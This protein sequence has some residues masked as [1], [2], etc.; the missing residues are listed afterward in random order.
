MAAISAADINAG[1][2]L[3]S[4]PSTTCL[5]KRTR[6]RVAYGALP[7]VGAVAGVR[8]FEGAGKQQPRLVSASVSTP[9]NYTF[10]FG[11][12][13]QRP[14]L[15]LPGVSR[16]QQAAY[17]P[18][19]IHVTDVNTTHFTIGNQFT[20][21]L[22]LD[23]VLLDGLTDDMTY[24]QPAPSCNSNGACNT[25]G[26]RVLS[27]PFVFPWP[28]PS[29]HVP[30]AFIVVPEVVAGG[31]YAPS[32]SGST[33]ALSGSP[34][35]SISMKL[36]PTSG[37]AGNITAFTAGFLLT[38]H[39]ATRA[40][41]YRYEC[42][43][44]SRTSNTACPLAYNGPTGANCTDREMDIYIA[45][46]R[47]MT[48][49]PDIALS[50]IAA[51]GNPAFNV[52]FE[53]YVYGASI[54]GFTLLITA[55]CTTRLWA[56]EVSWLAVSVT[57]APTPFQ[58]VGRSRYGYYYR[59]C[60]N[61]DNA[62]VL[63]YTMS[64]NDAG[65]TIERCAALTRASNLTFFGIRNGLD[66][67]AGNEG[68]W[69]LRSYDT[70]AACAVPC[71]GSASMGCGDAT[72]MSVYQLA[73][74][75]FTLS[76]QTDLSGAE[77][78]CRAS[79]GV[80]AMPLSGEESAA[81]A[82]AAAG[83]LNETIGAP[84]VQLYLRLGMWRN[85][86]TPSTDRETGW[87]VA[88][89]RP[90][91][92]NYLNWRNP[93]IGPYPAQPNGNAGDLCAIGFSS[94]VL[95]EDN[96]C[97]Y[98][99]TPVFAL[100]EQVTW[101]GCYADSS[102]TPFLPNYLGWVGGIEVCA[103][104]ARLEGYSLFA[105]RA[106]TNCYG[107]NDSSI[108]TGATRGT[109][110]VD[111]S[112]Y[113]PTQPRN[114]QLLK[115]GGSSASA[116]FTAGN[117]FCRGPLAN[118]GNM[119]ANNVPSS[120]T[121]L[122]TFFDRNFRAAPV[123]LYALH[124][125][126][127]PSQTLSVSLNLND[128]TWDRLTF[129][130]DV[131]NMTYGGN[132]G[133]LEYMEANWLALDGLPHG[134]KVTRGI[135]CSGG[136]C[137]GASSC[138]SYSYPPLA[139]GAPLPF[140]AVWAT[141]DGGSTASLSGNTL[142]ICPVS[143]SS[144]NTFRADLVLVD[145]AVVQTGWVKWACPAGQENNSTACP[146]SAVSGCTN[147][148]H[149]F[150]G[151]FDP[152]F[153]SGSDVEVLLSLVAVEA[154]CTGGCYGVD[155]G[156]VN[157]N[158]D[159]D[160]VLFDMR[161]GC[162]TRIT[163]FTV[164]WMAVLRSR[165]AGDTA[166]ACM[167]SPRRGGIKRLGCYG[168]ASLVPNA[169][170]PSTLRQNHPSMTIRRCAEAARVYGSN[171]FAIVNGTK[172]FGGS[173]SSMGGLPPTVALSQCSVGCSGDPSQKCGGPGTMSVFGIYD[174]YQLSTAD[175]MANT[176][177]V[178]LAR[179]PATVASAEDDTIIQSLMTA[180][181]I[182]TAWVGLRMSGAVP[183]EPP[184]LWD[185]RWAWSSGATYRDPVNSI[186]APLTVAFPGCTVKDSTQYGAANSQFATLY[187]VGWTGCCAAC[188][189]NTNC[190]YWS[191]RPSDSSCQL[192]GDQ[193]TSYWSYDANYMSGASPAIQATPDNRPTFALWHTLP[194]PR[195]TSP[196]C[197]A[198]RMTT[199]A[200]SSGQPPPRSGRA[201]RGLAH[202][203]CSQYLPVVCESLMWIPE[204]LGQNVVFEGCWRHVPTSSVTLPTRISA[205]SADMTIARCAQLANN[206][207]MPL[208]GLYRGGECWGGNGTAASVKAG[209]AAAQCNIPCPMQ[210]E[211]ETQ[212]C[213][214]LS[215]LLLFSQTLAPYNNVAAGRPAYAS[216]VTRQGNSVDWS[217]AQG[218]SLLTDGRPLDNDT[219]TTNMCITTAKQA[220][221]WLG[222][223]LPDM[224]DVSRVRV[225]APPDCWLTNAAN[226]NSADPATGPSSCN[227][228]GL[229]NFEV[230]VGQNDK[231]QTPFPEFGSTNL[232]GSFSGNA[233]PGAWVEVVCT[234]TLQG[235]AVLIARPSGAAQ[236][237]GLAAC[238]IQVIGQPSAGFSSL[239]LSPA[240]SNM[241]CGS[242][243]NAVRGCMSS[244]PGS[245]VSNPCGLS[246]DSDNSTYWS[247]LING[248]GQELTLELKTA[249]SVCSIAVDWWCGSA[250]NTSCNMTISTLLNSSLVQPHGMF[251]ATAARM[252]HT[253]WPST[254]AMQIKIS[255]DANGVFT[256]VYEVKLM[257]REAGGYY[258]I[259]PTIPAAN[260]YVSSV[261]NNDNATYG[262]AKAV[263]SKWTASLPSGNC[264]SSANVSGAPSWISFDMGGSSLMDGVQFL[265]PDNITPFTG[266]FA[267]RTGW[268]TASSYTY[269]TSNAVTTNVSGTFYPG[270]VVDIP[271][272]WAGSFGAVS[273]EFQT[274]NTE[275][276]ICEFAL[277]GRLQVLQVFSPPPLPPS[278]PIPSGGGGSGNAAY[279]APVFASSVVRK[280][281]D[282]GFSQAPSQG[283]LTDGRPMPNETLTTG[284]CVTTAKM[285]Q[286]WFGIALPMLTQVTAVTLQAPPNCYFYNAWI[287]NSLAVPGNS[288]SCSSTGL[289][290][291][292]VRVG[293]GEL[294][295]STPFAD[296]FS[297]TSLCGSYAG[298]A[299]PGA[300]VTIN[301][302][303]AITGRTVVIV[304][305]SGAA[306][307]GLALCEVQ[308]LGSPPA[309]G[310]P[311]PPSPPS[312]SPTCS[313]MNNLFGDCDQYGPGTSG[314]CSAAYDG[315]NSTFWS[316][317]TDQANQ[318]L[319]LRLK[320]VLRVC[321]VQVDWA[322][323]MASA[324]KMSLSTGVFYSTIVVWSGL[325]TT[326]TPTTSYIYP[327]A[328][329]NHLVFLVDG[330]ATGALTAIY[331][332]RVFLAEAKGMHNFLPLYSPAPSAVLVASSLK[333]N[334]PI[335]DAGALIDNEWYGRL[336]SGW[337]WA[338][339]SS[340]TDVPWIAFNLPAQHA[341]RGVQLLLPD[342]ITSYSANVTVRAGNNTVNTTAALGSNPTCYVDSRTGG[343]STWS[344]AEVVSLYCNTSSARVITL[345]A[346]LPYWEWSLCDVGVWGRQLLS[347]AGGGVLSPS[348][349]YSPSPSPAAVATSV[350][351]VPL[352][353][354]YP[355]GGWASTVS[356][357]SY[358]A[359]DCSNGFATAVTL[360]GTFSTYLSYMSLR[361]CSTGVGSLS[362]PTYVGDGNMQGM[363]P[364][365]LVDFVCPD[366]FS[367]I[368][369]MQSDPASLAQLSPFEFKLW[370]TSGA[371]GRGEWTTPAIGSG[372]GAMSFKE[373]VVTCPVGALITGFKVHYTSSVVA[374]IVIECKPR[375]SG[376]AWTT[377]N[378][379][380]S[381]PAGYDFLPGY[382]DNTVSTLITYTK[383]NAT[384]GVPVI[385][386]AVSDCE[387]RS[388][389]VVIA[390]RVVN[391]TTS[392][393]ELLLQADTM[394]QA[395][396]NMWQGAGMKAPGMP[397]CE[398]SYWKTPRFPRQYFC[399]NRMKLSGSVLTTSSSATTPGACAMLCDG[400]S[401][402][403]GWYLDAA[404]STCS[405]F[406]MPF[407]ANTA[408]NVS[409]G[410]S[411][412]GMSC[413]L[414]NDPCDDNPA[415][416]HYIFTGTY[417]GE[418]NCYLRNSPF[419]GST[420]E[421]AN[422]PS[423]A[424]QRTCL[425]TMMHRQMSGS[426]TNNY[427]LTHSQ[428][429]FHG[430]RF[431]PSGAWRILGTVYDSSTCSAYCHSQPGCAWWEMLV[432]GSC[433]LHDAWGW[434]K[435][436]GFGPDSN[437]VIACLSAVTGLFECLPSGA[438]FAFSPSVIMAANSSANCASSCKATANCAAYH[439][440][441][442]ISMC[443]L[444]HQPFLGSIGINAVSGG[445]AGDAWCLRTLN[446][447]TMF[448]SGAPNIPQPATP[449]SFFQVE[450]APVPIRY[451]P[452]GGWTIFHSFY[453]MS[454]GALSGITI[455][456][457]SGAY[458][459][460]L[461][462]SSCSNNMAPNVSGMAFFGSNTGSASTVT[463]AGGGFD[464][465]RA[466]E[467]YKPPGGTASAM[468]PLVK[469]QFHC[470]NS[471][472][473][474]SS[475]ASGAG[476]TNNRTLTTI[477]CPAGTAITRL[478]FA[479]DTG[480]I[481]IIKIF[482]GA[483][484]APTPAATM[485]ACPSVPG[486]AL[487][488][489]VGDPSAVITKSYFSNQLA[490]FDDCLI[491]STCTAVAWGTTGGGG[492]YAHTQAADLALLQ[493][494]RPGDG[495]GSCDGTYVETPQ[496]PSQYYCVPGIFKGVVPN[497][498]LTSAYAATVAHCAYECESMGTCKGFLLDTAI[499]QGG[500]DIWDMKPLPSE[501][502][503][504]VSN[505]TTVVG[506][507]PTANT[508]Y[509]CLPDGVGF[510]GMSFSSPFRRAT[511]E[512]CRFDCDQDPGCYAYTF[513]PA[514][515]E[516][517][518][519]AELLAPS[520]SVIA[521][522]NARFRTCMKTPHHP[523]LSASGLGRAQGSLCFPGVDLGGVKT[524]TT[525]A[526]ATPTACARLCV[527]SGCGHWRLRTD[528]ACEL[529]APWTYLGM[530]AGS[531]MAY[532]TDADTAMSC[533]ARVTGTF[534]C[535]APNR[536]IA[537]D[538]VAEL[539]LE[540]S[541]PPSPMPVPDTEAPALSLMGSEYLELEVFVDAYVEA[542][543]SLAEADQAVFLA[544]RTP[545]PFSL[546][547]C[548]AFADG[549]PPAQ[550]TCAA[551]AN[552][553]LNG[554]LTPAITSVVVPRCA[555]NTS[556]EDGTC[557]GCSV[558]AL[559]TGTCLPGRYSVTYT[560]AATDGNGGSASTSRRLDVA[561]EQLTTTII[562]LNLFPNRTA[563]GSAN[564]TTAA[565]FADSLLANST[566][567]AALLAPV[568][569]V[570]GITPST[571]RNV[572][573][574]TPP[575]VVPVYP[576]P[577]AANSTNTTTGGDGTAAVNGT[578]VAASGN[579]ATAAAGSN[580]TAAG[581][582]TTASGNG[583]ALSPNNSTQAA[584]SYYVVRTSSC[585]TSATAPNASSSAGASAGLA[586]VGTVSSA[587]ASPAVDATGV[588]LGVLAGAV[589]D[590]DRLAKQMAEQQS[591]M[592]TLLGTLD[593]K[594]SAKDEVYRTSI[595]LMSAEADTAFNA[596][597]AKAQRLLELVGKTLAQQNANAGALVAT[598]S[599]LQNS[600]E[601][602]PTGLP[603][604][605]FHQP[606]SGLPPGYPLLL[607]T[608][609][610]AQRAEQ[611]IT[612][613]RDGGY[614]SATLTKSM[615]A[616]LVSCNPDAQVFGYWRLDMT[617]LDSGVIS[618]STKLLGLPA[619]S[620]G[621]SITNLQVGHFLPDFFLVLL[622]IGY[623]IMT[624]LDIYRQLQSQKRRRR[625]LWRRAKDQLSRA[626]A[627][628][629]FRR[630][631]AVAAA[632]ANAGKGAAG[633][634]NAFAPDGGA[635]VGDAGGDDSD[636]DG[637]EDEDDGGDPRGIKAALGIKKYRPK[638]SI[639][640][641]CYEALICALMA[642]SI[643]VFYTYA[644]RLSV[645]DD[646]TARFDV[647]DALT[648]ARARY[649]LLA[650]DPAASAAAA[651]AAAATAAG[652]SSNFTA[653][654]TMGLVNSTS[655]TV[656]STSTSS[657][658]ATGA[659]PGSAGRW[660]LP[661]DT[662]PLGDAGAMYARV[663]DMY[664]MYVLYSF[665]Q[666]IVLVLI[667]VRW[668]H[669]ISFQPR[670]SIIPGTLAL[671]LPDL[672]HFAV[673]VLLCVV[674]FASAAAL[675]YGP[676][677]SQL[678][679]PGS[680]VYLMLR[681]VLLRS[682]DSVFRSIV[683]ST[684]ERTGAEDVL[685]WLL[686][687]IGPLFFVFLLSN[688]IMVRAP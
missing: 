665:L 601:L 142:S 588:A 261:K 70:A 240:P 358:T 412:L 389:C 627:A 580:T 390:Q 569:L 510:S 246:Y 80:L 181:S 486:F 349:N 50:I 430:V 34:P 439:Y 326:T 668:L 500:C 646:F 143:G 361:N 225:L 73:D 638:M 300:L 133:T 74:R 463:C 447:A 459:T 586:S 372:Q 613:I 515:F 446:Y 370:C 114:G 204:H 626:V 9:G 401:G 603:Y 109:C 212:P 18:Y 363:Q 330:L 475:F 138:W 55:I 201:M 137:P 171:M 386:A 71:A 42:A 90:L 290:D 35:S 220:R 250:G 582:G 564:A 377:P 88:S 297:G 418:F 426:Y 51:D 200:V 346:N 270:Q 491:D 154:V 82:E 184:M 41:T 308:V 409:T 97:T 223:L 238:E 237:L 87:A 127:R 423:P 600:T 215:G 688:F 429:C 188:A 15:V 5:L 465:V 677:V 141:A 415:C 165:T 49:A 451:T 85:G 683:Q 402:C 357:P 467:A 571:I 493:G 251:N 277:I 86:S 130:V 7:A 107:G 499:L 232:C 161:A 292:E 306:P 274:A 264:W 272:S 173:L 506:C 190:S 284:F 128:V 263:D 296:V 425:K 302:T 589:S 594:F 315:D 4:S 675:A 52:Y 149:S 182:S 99:L 388:S 391:E 186:G 126:R 286:P 72:R 407:V 156:L 146:L 205:F 534:E 660:K 524:G 150:S 231:L 614:L 19:S 313:L 454:G 350:R 503:F 558:A 546:A 438:T 373:V 405:L 669:Y 368:V 278:P 474:T 112:Y 536:T 598:L 303:T 196:G 125:L 364:S 8:G 413:W 514:T 40:G 468:H 469:V 432:D 245:G 266:T 117:L 443:R 319:T 336:S 653:G 243:A 573:F 23:V 410:T 101:V 473:W 521:P 672:L 227:S 528:G 517:R 540:A 69:G 490:A 167:A 479:I 332:V 457:A 281:F 440:D 214:G 559:T 176:T 633:G 211:G 194:E 152:S 366:G 342:N 179:M 61:F 233:T 328:D 481:T 406:D 291:L 497:G 32:D 158:Y 282:I 191:F 576:V 325:A 236:P 192:K 295:L 539:S 276:Q 33:V 544:Y 607:D 508:P 309:P 320:S 502:P 476:L 239:T 431:G 631:T 392:S 78:M 616:Q 10:A 199:A 556:V 91:T 324:C 111:C 218:T 288:S 618:A 458:L 436:G 122:T 427:A 63:M 119:T 157:Q 356:N 207:R 659:E 124:M 655:S 118:T 527:S 478:N 54:Y 628:A 408:F 496:L 183:G 671:A 53:V 501:Y 511:P 344:A 590:L 105:V 670:L 666:G 92:G 25:T 219:L 6:G 507:W 561:V 84:L 110:D 195:F 445:A 77:G 630:R 79:G 311:P 554:D 641:I 472:G 384:G 341:L 609:L 329:A 549:A 12:T 687:M 123:L 271:C 617:W 611:A 574:I 419:T 166:G 301:C 424:A 378:S 684:S 89:G 565:A 13:Y 197:V 28:M 327:G 46:D 381:W 662:E 175:A 210:D 532:G 395:G 131:G 452:S 116:V 206:A 258:N 444:G 168:S 487:L 136:L 76:G 353:R 557:S 566:A 644:V 441:S 345:Q 95:W 230:L 113:N 435:N 1:R 504:T 635:G 575:T 608:Q 383:G 448:S 132:P 629:G 433:V 228:T 351:M 235:R 20:S 100:P 663:D 520:T 658:N 597:S 226:V 252:T 455:D 466:E 577:G 93:V 174:R 399:V 537:Y 456:D 376:V 513:D 129:F 299:T 262:D 543:L 103:T 213:G 348:P 462:G 654:V 279:N 48:A 533:L 379:Q 562:E 338:S 193:G 584:P 492:L 102:G 355:G 294:D 591:T 667:I 530:G 104:K 367:A 581:N 567:R 385:R 643:A 555:A 144:I 382:F 518:L 648:F 254:D 680:A 460:Y 606:L 115:C 177:C 65:M 145:T 685:A 563:D 275:L 180:S 625:L 678:A 62:A 298:A 585:G 421:F 416:S 553:T 17:G 403:L 634:G 155:V 637:V 593:D 420:S 525:T 189:A 568:M 47:P 394:S 461:A 369:G 289:H 310:P 305:S 318:E 94:D 98:G 163:S 24:I 162:S 160:Q 75:F 374:R 449:L 260:R 331:E 414:T 404:N 151:S 31:P 579:N 398:G 170:L 22:D 335:Y 120:G 375:S 81:V 241:G 244:G 640:W 347:V 450:M 153:P 164:N 651:A 185:T 509:L 602:L 471:G 343:S 519:Y 83:V 314:N 484:T 217:Y 316:R 222:V 96:S 636:S 495:G 647:Y 529:Y 604:G 612:F 592:V 535:L 255:I 67:Y 198:Y 596:T 36:C 57:S 134:M 312:Y 234:S 599:V 632:A 159:T 43:V 498:I 208:F 38:D 148:F 522:A 337:C 551:I 27:Q 11:V 682:D 26:C 202:S 624:A 257:L 44:G 172:C 242:L 2:H 578:A 482:C 664:N 480:T 307:A 140:V 434:F 169:V 621:Q 400:A 323:S 547:P 58:S 489:N 470:S 572:I 649:F 560:V 656:S 304:R 365:N 595:K 422:G 610:S 442:A 203:D 494:E 339:D 321:Q 686:Y 619:I 317:N 108:L 464:A 645:R 285:R 259:I 642:A 16:F 587:C 545:A 268:T 229:S 280:G 248:T 187:V 37:G 542:N 253:V 216:S 354:G 45:F 293:Y 483:P 657:S 224:I 29:S 247:R 359:L 620:Y 39:P 380:C 21:Y 147:R 674:M 531:A 453:C 121:A 411:G 106:Q 360:G 333:N 417:N 622:V 30:N 362:G 334:D 639:K 256:G 267:L 68:V 273:M 322:C 681:Y 283:I 221:S 287:T 64:T 516:C 548:A 550:P 512:Q 14:P 679:S 428:L 505:S 650:R 397:H 249:Y 477:T 371:G 66:C 523:D 605:F 538:Q 178:S 396:L 265:I 393:M 570:F 3:R 615:R 623:F 583:T 59:G 139:P 676:G 652:L 488:P 352:P 673:V 209:R 135:G 526:T 552:D 56:L 60:Y 269:L 541:R 387:S 437:V 340:S 661:A 485:D